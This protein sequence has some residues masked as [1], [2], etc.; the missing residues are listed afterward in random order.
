[1][2]CLST[3]LKNTPCG[4]SRG[5]MLKLNGSHQ[6]VVYADCVNGLRANINNMRINSE[7]LIDSTKGVGP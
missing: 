4:R 2:H 6:S 1:M 3:L 7:A 5:T